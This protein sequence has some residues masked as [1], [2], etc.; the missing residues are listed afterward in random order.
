MPKGKDYMPDKQ[1]DFID[2]QDNLIKQVVLNAIA[3]LI[4][5]GKVSALQAAQAAY[6]PLYNVIKVKQNRT[7]KQVDAHQVGRKKYEKILRVFVKENLVGN[8]AIP[9][10]SKVAMGINP[11]RNGAGHRSAIDIAPNV[12]LK[13]LG[14]LQ[15]L[16]ECRVETDTGR[17]RLH[18]EADVI[19]F[20]SSVSSIAPEGITTSQPNPPRGDNAPPAN[21]KEAK[22]IQF[23]S[24]ARFKIE[25]PNPDWA[26]KY[27]YAF[28]RYKNI[29]DEA[30]NGK[31][32]EV[33]H[34]RIG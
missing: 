27:L 4:S 7:M 6:L 15:I 16:V 25:L 23:S 32:S 26:G 12:V 13:A 30:K 11:G 22:D 31:W 14:G 19:E 9:H 17:P 3:W 8:T 5:N 24:K 20:R 10:D 21:Y 18:P 28:A 33:A 1:K 29:T 34:V 2:W